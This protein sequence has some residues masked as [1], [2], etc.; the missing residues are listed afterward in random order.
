MAKP[1]KAAAVAPKTARLVAIMAFAH[2][3]TG[4]WARGETRELPVNDTVAA[5]VKAGNL[6]AVDGTAPIP[7]STPAVPAIPAG[8]T[9]E[10]TAVMAFNRP[11]LG[12]WSRGETRTVPVDDA[13]TAAI[14]DG[15]LRAVPESPA[16]RA[17][18]PAPAT[19][20]DPADVAGTARVRAVMAFSSPRHGDWPKNETRTVPVDDATIVLVESGYLEP[21]WDAPPPAISG[22]SVQ[23][24][25]PTGQVTVYPAI[26]SKQE[27]S[28][29]DPV[30]AAAAAA[31]ASANPG[32]GTP[33]LRKRR[34]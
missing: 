32:R 10:L 28:G 12:A 22:V 26:K 33:R 9:S 21:V 16:A 13:T 17:A 18:E 24:P 34:H 3:E 20:P 4:A 14:R 8:D 27:V 5:L 6:R 29:V 11:G 2:P 23:L 25:S 15:Y 31:H 1:K 30:W 19:P 7:A